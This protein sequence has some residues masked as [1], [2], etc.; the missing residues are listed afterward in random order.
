MRINRH[1]PGQPIQPRPHKAG[2]VPSEPGGAI[3]PPGKYWPGHVLVPSD[4]PTDERG[5]VWEQSETGKMMCMKT[6]DL[7][8]RE[9]LTLAAIRA[10]TE[11]I[12]PRHGPSLNP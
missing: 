10:E 5:Y 12:R 6:W 3:R 11:Q 8:A 9:R 4:P 7:S 1:L 2:G